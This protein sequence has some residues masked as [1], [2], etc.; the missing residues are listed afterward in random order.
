MLFAE[1]KKNLTW[2]GRMD[3]IR[4]GNEMGCLGVLE[5]RE[6]VA[7]ALVE[8]IGLLVQAQDEMWRAREAALTGDQ[9]GVKG[10]LAVADGL[11]VEVNARGMIVTLLA[12]R[13]VGDDY[14][15]GLWVRWRGLV[16]GVKLVG[17]TVAN[18]AARRRT[19]HL[20]GQ[21]WPN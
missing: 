7:R 2:M 15:T 5:P 16:E 6:V 10:S 3:R 13:V 11:M 8:G 14:I 19:V 4:K 21:C 12:D 17:K 18:V 20:A 9:A 1:G